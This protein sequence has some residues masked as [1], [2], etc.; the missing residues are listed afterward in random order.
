MDEYERASSELKRVL[1]QT[2]DNEYSQIVDTQTKD[3]ECRSIQTIMTHVV[4]SGYGYANYIRDLFSIAS[5]RP[6]NVLISRR[7]VVAQLDAMLDY[8][9]QTLDGKWEMTDEKMDNAVIH[10]GWG[11]TYTLEQLLEHAIVHILRHR[12]QIERFKEEMSGE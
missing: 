9:V 7:E 5:A 4:N 12:R 10:S 3:E 8:T 1:E 2:L 11:V 6:P